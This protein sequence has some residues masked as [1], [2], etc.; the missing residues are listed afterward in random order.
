MA[1]YSLNVAN[2]QASNQ[3]TL[4]REYTLSAAYNQGK[5][6]FLNSSNQWQ[7]VAPGSALGSNVGDL[8]GMLATAGNTNQPATVITED[9]NLS[10]GPILTNGVPVWASP[11]AGNIGNLADLGSGNAPVFLG[12]PRTTSTLFFKPVTGGRAI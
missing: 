12:L 10:L 8:V 7:A 9:P 3:A 1:D 11:N 2:V 6:V 4:R 5:I